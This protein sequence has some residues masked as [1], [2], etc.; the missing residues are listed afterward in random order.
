M[1]KKYFP[2]IPIVGIIL[3]G[4][5]GGLEDQ[6]EAGFILSAVWQGIAV[7]AVLVIPILILL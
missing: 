1:N 6:S 2:W 5:Y 4:L 3:I 7:S